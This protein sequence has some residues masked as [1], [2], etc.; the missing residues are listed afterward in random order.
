M[1][2]VCAGDNSTCMCVSYHG[3]HVEEM[4]YLLL[5]WTINQTISQ[6]D[7]ALA[8]LYLSLQNIENYNGEADLGSVIRYMN[9]WLLGCH[10][11]YEFKIEGINNYLIAKILFVF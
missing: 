10:E 2:G 3:Y 1:C 4:D 8:T 7:S 6:I 9:G 11:P 5:Q